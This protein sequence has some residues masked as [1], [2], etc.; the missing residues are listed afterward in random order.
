MQPTNVAVIGSGIS[1]LTAAHQLN[2]DGHRVR[3]FE[4]EATLGGHATTIE[5]DGLNVDIG[6]IVYNEMTYPRFIGLL[7]ELGVE[8]QPSDMSMGVA[9][10]TCKV[11]WSTRGLQ[12]VFARPM[13]LARPSHYAMLNDLFRFYRDA[14]ATLDEADAGRPTGMTLDEYLADRRLGNAFANHFLVPLTA[15]VWST[16]PDR[17]GSFPVDYLL[18]FLDHHGLIGYGRNFTWRTVAGGSQA[19]V[20]RIIERLPIG[21]AEA[22]NPVRGIRRDAAGVTIETAHGRPERFDAV[23]LATHADQALR[24]LRDADP[25][26]RSALGGFDYSDNR[27]VLHTDDGILPRRRN[28]WASWNIDMGS[29]AAPGD[30]LTM[31]YHM[32]R[33]QSL[34]GDEQYSVSLNPPDGRIRE[35]RVLLERDW[36]HPMYTFRTLEAQRLIRGIQ[37]RNR[38]FYAG[39]HLGYGFHEDGCRSGYEAAALVAERVALPETEELVA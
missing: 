11:E 26:E 23:V 3:L 15:A 38:T 24:L 25:D 22:G 5:V 2:K 13:Q 4:R 36:S 7:D 14:R 8:T 34:P 27:V 21:A 37:G 9:C 20:R 10:A 28:A 29:C 32:N 31:T 18:R 6:F 33:L 16:A 39:A 1:G 30:E 17:I 35:D 12:G 19:Y